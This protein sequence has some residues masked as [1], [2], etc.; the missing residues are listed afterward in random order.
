MGGGQERRDRGVEDLGHFSG[1]LGQDRVL[2]RVPAEAQRLD[3]FLAILLLE[4]LD[5][6]DGGFDR[7]F[8]VVHGKAA[9]LPAGRSLDVFG[10]RMR[11]R[12]RL[13]KRH[14]L[15]A[16]VLQVGQ[17]DGVVAAQVLDVPPSILQHRVHTVCVAGRCHVVRSRLVAMWCS[18][19]DAHS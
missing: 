1:K 14:A 7:V 18:V 13:R 16:R 9:L 2:V 12:G 15:R 3:L 10:R 8:D 19:F 4:P 17:Q 11:M 6:G 5:F